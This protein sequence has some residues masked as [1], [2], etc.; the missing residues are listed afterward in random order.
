MKSFVAAA[1]VVAVAFLALMATWRA[2][3]AIGV[4]QAPEHDVGTGMDATKRELLDEKLRHLRSLKEV[5]FDHQ[6][7]KLDD[8]DYASLRQ[9]HERA[10]AE[11]IRALDVLEGRSGS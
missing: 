2:L 10:A 1:A 5:E 6:T 4:L 7:G 3:R 9:R 8:A 11:A